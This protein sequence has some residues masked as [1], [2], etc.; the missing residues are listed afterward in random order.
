MFLNST[1][2][3]HPDQRQSNKI[4]KSLS[5]SSNEDINKKS[6]TQKNKER[7]GKGKGEKKKKKKKEEEKLFS[8]RERN[9]S[10][11]FHPNSEKNF[12]NNNQNP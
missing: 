10:L 9:L 5:L 7:G 11:I 4:P 6:N 12:K 8:F 2:L 3:S 1:L